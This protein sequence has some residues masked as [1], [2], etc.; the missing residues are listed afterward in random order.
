MVM[1]RQK[2]RWLGN[3]YPCWATGST[4]CWN[5]WRN[6]ISNRALTFFKAFSIG[7]GRS[8]AQSCTLSFAGVKH[9]K[10]KGETHVPKC[11]RLCVW[12]LYLEMASKHIFTSYWGVKTC[13]NV[14][15]FYYKI[16]VLCIGHILVMKEDF[17]SIHVLS[18]CWWK[19]VT[20]QNGRQKNVEKP[21]FGHLTASKMKLVRRQ[22]L[23]NKQYIFFLQN[24]K[25][26]FKNTWFL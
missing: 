1:G 3:F 11:S 22:L 7:C 25:Q 21:T 2:W 24:K 16:N 4:V 18:Q 19:V 9:M 14:C 12:K 8:M 5:L 23:P 17:T 10:N 20:T 15:F 26:I 6:G 13:I